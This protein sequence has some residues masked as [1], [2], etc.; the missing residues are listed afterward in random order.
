MEWDFRR[1]HFVHLCQERRSSY[2][3]VF[4]V[5]LHFHFLPTVRW[6]PAYDLAL[7][8]LLLLLLTPNLILANRIGIEGALALADSLMLNTT[9]TE[10]DLAST[11]E[12]HKWL[13]CC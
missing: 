1:F 10:L 8:L 7:L 9:L 5:F 12:L 2:I 4:L 11:L 3:L 13:F 6:D